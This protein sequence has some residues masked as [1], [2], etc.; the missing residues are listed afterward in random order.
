MEPIVISAH[1]TQKKRGSS[2][3]NNSF[4]HHRPSSIK[5]RESYKRSTSDSSNSSIGYHRNKPKCQICDQIG[6]T[7]KYSPKYS[8]QNVT[9]CA[10]S[11]KRSNTKW[12]VDSAASH[13]MTNLSNL[14]IHSKYTGIDE[15]VI[16]DGSSFP[17]SYIGS[18]SFASPTRVFHLCD[19]LYVPNIRKK[20][21]SFHPLFYQA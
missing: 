2:F 20:K 12:L 10:T 6:H 21:V 5:R 9:A 1:Y 13:N 15:V 16:G 11:V 19:T 4:D 17:V 14:F 8:N 3:P 7:A 18:L